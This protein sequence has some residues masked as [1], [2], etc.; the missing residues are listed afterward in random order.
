MERIKAWAVKKYFKLS[1]HD[2]KRKDLSLLLDK[3][4]NYAS[5]NG[6][7]QYRKNF[8]KALVAYNCPFFSKEVYRVKPEFPN[9]F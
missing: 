2:V 6:K 9:P 5:S 7:E 1:L 4:Y 3:R 8:I